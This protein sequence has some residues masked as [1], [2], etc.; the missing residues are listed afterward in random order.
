M[1]VSYCVTRRTLTMSCIWQAAQRE[2][3]RHALA[4]QNPEREFPAGPDQRERTNRTFCL[5]GMLSMNDQGLQESRERLRNAGRHTFSDHATLY[6]DMTIE[7]ETLSRSSS[8][9]KRGKEC[10]RVARGPVTEP[11]NRCFRR[12]LQI[13]RLHRGA[14]VKQRCRLDPGHSRLYAQQPSRD[15]RCRNE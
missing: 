5:R 14:A 15:D 4:Q 12:R 3:L 1:S 8:G 11:A 6:L 13:D 9:A 7:E 2:L 10:C